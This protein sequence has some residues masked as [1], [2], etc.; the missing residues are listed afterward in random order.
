MSQHTPEETTIGEHKYEMFMLAP[1]QSH[2]LFIDVAKMVGPAIGP[3]IDALLKKSSGELGLAE[4]MEQELSGDF[5]TKALT[6]LFSG[7]DKKVLRDVIQAFKGMTH[8][9]GMPL[10]KTFDAHFHGKLNELYEW[11]LWG[12]RVQWG[13]SLS[14]LGKGLLARGAAAMPVLKSQS[15][16]T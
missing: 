2:E 9:D 1:M 14:A 7:L 3:A 11:L 4:L 16:S 12:M 8:V 5:F 6:S 10:E 13:K 15:P